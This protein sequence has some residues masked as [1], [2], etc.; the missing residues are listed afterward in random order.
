MFFGQNLPHL[1][2]ENGTVLEV[3]SEENRNDTC[4]ESCSMRSSYSHDL[5][6]ICDK[7]HLQQYVLKGIQS[8]FFKDKTNSRKLCFQSY[9]ILLF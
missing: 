5:G 6:M 1:C 9:E 7:A 3:Y 4:G 8:E 2:A